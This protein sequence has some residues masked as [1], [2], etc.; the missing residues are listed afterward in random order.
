MFEIEIVMIEYDD[1]TDPNEIVD[2]ADGVDE[3]TGGAAV[4]LNVKFT[5]D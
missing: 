4:Q 2:G 3:N 1:D 5:L